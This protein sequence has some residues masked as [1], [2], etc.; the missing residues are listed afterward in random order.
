M[1][2]GLALGAGDGDERSASLAV[3]LWDREDFPK[4][5]WGCLGVTDYGRGNLQLCPACEAARFRYGHLLRHPGWG[6]VMVGCDCAGLLEGS[7]EGARQREAAALGHAQRVKRNL[8]REWRTTRSGNAKLKIVGGPLLVVYRQ[9]CSPEWYR[10]Q[11][12]ED[13]GYLHRA[14]LPFPLE[15]HAR[16]AAVRWALGAG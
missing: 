15:E 9:T 12:I 11:A 5:G 6:D 13:G 2:P 16:E 3:K 10:W 1:R 14:S 7:T 4:S 8:T